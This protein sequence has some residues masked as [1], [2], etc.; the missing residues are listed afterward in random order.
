M[1]V[2]GGYSGV[3]FYRVFVHISVFM[4]G[5]IDLHFCRLTL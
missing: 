3:H 1:K 5:P 4:F 2:K